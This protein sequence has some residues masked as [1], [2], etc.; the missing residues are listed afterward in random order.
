VAEA[1]R[2]KAEALQARKVYDAHKKRAEEEAS[3]RALETAQMIPAAV[4]AKSLAKMMR[5]RVSKT[6]HERVSLK[7]KIEEE[8]ARVARALKRKEKLRVVKARLQAEE[9]HR[10]A[11]KN[12]SVGLAEMSPSSDSTGK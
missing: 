6:I 5:M 8:E 12:L 3:R 9:K 2:E 11:I 1:K 7:R 10:L 4:T